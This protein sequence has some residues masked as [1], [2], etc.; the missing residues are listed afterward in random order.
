MACM[1]HEGDCMKMVFGVSRP[2]ENS[3]V[4]IH[5]MITATRLVTVLGCLCV[6]TMVV[7]IRFGSSAVGTSSRKFAV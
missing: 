2:L 6:V 3:K 4:I 5:C 7:T 1:E